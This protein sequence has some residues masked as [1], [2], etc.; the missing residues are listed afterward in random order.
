M[1]RR[2]LT[3]LP[4]HLPAQDPSA[5]TAEAAT[6]RPA[7]RATPPIARVAGAEATAAALREVS[8]A[9]AGA[10][11]EGRLA[12][13]LTLDQIEDGWLVR[14]RLA[15]EG[16]DFAA[17]L[18]SLRAH[19]QRTAIEV[20]E[21]APGRYGLISGWRRLTALR[22]L[23]RD[24]G[25]ARFATVLAVLRRPEGAAEAYVAM[26]EENEIRAGLSYYERARI[27]ARAAEAG[28]F[29]GD[30]AALQ[31]LFGATSRARRSKIGS[32]IGIYRTLDGVLRHPAAI[33]ERLGLR[34]AQALEDDAQ[35]PRRLRA[36]LAQAAPT[37]PEAELGVLEDLL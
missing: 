21:L 29:P 23:H 31:A 27:V 3:P 10:R 37:T 18:A 28:V 6:S 14:D 36:G 9:L 1:A 8:D 34:L 24:T 19:G 12:L 35:F 25:E 11:A 17:L 26:V 15:P 22:A 5:G 2:R 30:R 33:P 13:R 20:S 4:S 16:E 7:D 32:F